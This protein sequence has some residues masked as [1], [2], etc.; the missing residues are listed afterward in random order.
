MLI[1]T[2][3]T[4]LYEKLYVGPRPSHPMTYD[5]LTSS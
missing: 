4:P 5:N 2:I 3:Y 1:V